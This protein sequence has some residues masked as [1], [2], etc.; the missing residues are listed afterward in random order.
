MQEVR[1]CLYYEDFLSIVESLLFFDK[2]SVQFPNCF[3]CHLYYTKLLLL[4]LYYYNYYT[5]AL[6]KM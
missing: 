6:P 5:L 3:V 2:A 4:Y 1:G